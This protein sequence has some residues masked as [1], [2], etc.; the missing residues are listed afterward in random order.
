MFVGKSPGKS[1]SLLGA[2]GNKEGSTKGL[3]AKMGNDIINGS[4]EKKENNYMLQPGPGSHYNTDSKKVKLSDQKGHGFNPQE[5]CISLLGNGTGPTKGPI[6]ATQA[7]I[8]GTSVKTT[9][10]N[11]YH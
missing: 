5:L 1:I 4:V 11:T 10:E 2:A 3:F 6:K 9:M 7:A 8:H